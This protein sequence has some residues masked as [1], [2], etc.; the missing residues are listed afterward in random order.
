MPL[1]TRWPNLRRCHI[2]S[3]FSLTWS[4]INVFDVALVMQNFQCIW[5]VAGC[6]CNGEQAWASSG[7]H[8]TRYHIL[9]VIFTSP[10]CGEV[11]MVATCP[12]LGSMCLCHKTFI[13]D[14]KWLLDRPVTFRPSRGRW[15]EQRRTGASWIRTVNFFSKQR[16]FST[17]ETNLTTFY[18]G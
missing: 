12:L 4:L 10:R 8:F 1:R 14:R 7:W 18:G 3:N 15:A 11:N 17:S 5:C 2:V 9:C 6:Q 16:N 13:V